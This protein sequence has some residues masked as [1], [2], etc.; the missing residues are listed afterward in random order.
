MLSDCL[1]L[2]KCPHT[3]SLQACK[4]TM[5]FLP[6]ALNNT[7]ETLNKV[8]QH[9]SVLPDPELYIIVNGRPTKSNIVWRSLVNVDH[10]RTAIR[11]LR[12]CNWLYRDI[13]EKCIEESTKQCNHGNVE[14][15]F[16]R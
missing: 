16:P 11:K 9:T 7:I 13:H 3:I 6:L 12:S 2:V 5:F 1:T 15:G 4:G 14:K 8:Q 10:V